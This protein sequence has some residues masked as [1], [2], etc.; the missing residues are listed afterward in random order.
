MSE[1][2]VLLRPLAEGD[3]NF[4]LNSWLKSYEDS[5]WTKVAGKAYWKGHRIAIL[6]LIRSAHVVIACD[7]EDHD[8]ILGW[9]CTNGR[10]VHYVYVKRAFRR[11]GLAKRLLADHV[12]MLSP[13]VYTHRWNPILHLIPPANWTYDPYPALIGEYDEAA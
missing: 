13:V 12:K 5:G 11:Y 1:L 3:V 9:A 7:P 4:V 2:P 10:Y 8:T 6:R